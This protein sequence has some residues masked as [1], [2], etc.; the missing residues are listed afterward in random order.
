[1]A[2]SELRIL[3]TLNN[4]ITRGLSEA[5]NQLDS[6]G[7]RAEKIGKSL[8]GAG[9]RIAGIGAAGQAALSRMGLDMGTLITGAVDAEKALYGIASTAGKSGAAAKA[10]VSEWTIA[11]NQIAKETNQNQESVTAAMSQLIA[12]GMDPSAAVEML[13]PI[14]RAATAAQGDILDMAI[15]I[16]AGFSKFGIAPAEAAKSLDIMAQAGKRGKFE[17]KDMAGYFESL[18]AQAD[19]LGIKGQAGMAQLAAAAQI[20]RRASGDAASAANNLGN[21]LGKLNA[22]TTAKN[23]QE[24]GADLGKLKE[25]ARASGDYIG[26]M[27]TA[28]QKLTAGDSEKIASLFPDM[29]A[30]KFIQRMVKDLGDYKDIFADSMQ[31]NGVVAEDFKTQMQ[32]TA[33]QMDKLK[34]G[35]TASAGEGGALRGIMDALNDLASWADNHPDLAKWIIFGT[36][37]LVVGGAVIM[38]I[39]A[40][41]T[42]IGGIVTALSTLSVFLAANPVVL[43]ILGIGAAFTAGWA[44]GTWLNGQIDLAVQAVTGNQFATL[45]TAIYDMVQ[46]FADIPAKL[47]AQFEAWKAAGAALIANLKAGI[48]DK[49]KGAFGIGEKIKD[50]L[51]YVIDLHAEWLQVGRNIIQGIINGL[52]QKYKEVVDKLK[53]LGTDMLEGV[54]GVLRM[55]S[56]SKETEEIGMYFAEGMS[57]GIS[58]GSLGVVRSVEDMARAALDAGYAFDTLGDPLGGLADDIDAIEKGAAQAEKS[59]A[60]MAASAKNMPTEKAANYRDSKGRYL[61]SDAAERTAE[62]WRRTASDIERSLT[63]ALMRGFEGGKD[64]GRNFVDTIKNYLQTAFL[65]PIAV[66]IS[67]S[68]MG[69]VGL[70]SGTAIAGGA[71]V[72]ES[73]GMV[74]SLKTA[75]NAVTTGFAALGE[76]VGMYAGGIV[77]SLGASSAAAGS[78]GAAVATAMPWVI[79][80]VAVASAWKS[81]FGRKLKDSGVEGTF[82]DG[83]FTGN[84]YEYLKGGLFRSDKTNRSP[85]DSELDQAF[86]AQYAAQKMGNLMANAALGGVSTALDDFSH[87]IKLSLK[88]LNEEDAQKKI[89]EA[90]SGMNDAMATEV[91]NSLAEAQ[92]LTGLQDRS[93]KSIIQ[94][95]QYAVNEFG[96]LEYAMQDT[97]I[98]TIIPAVVAEWQRFALLGETASQTLSRLSTSLSGVNVAFDTLGLAL[99][100]V[101]LSGA[102]MA[103]SLATLFGGL[104]NMQQMTGAYYDAYY[105]D[106]EKLANT[107]SAVGNALG[108]LGTPMQTTKEGF[109]SLV[110]GLDLTTAYGQNAFVTLMG[111][112]PAFSTVADAAVENAKKTAEAEIARSK[113]IA[114]WQN[115]INVLTG[116]FTDQQIERAQT[117][118]TAAET[119]DTELVSLI[120]HFYALEDSTKAA[121]TATEGLKNLADAFESAAQAARDRTSASLESLRGE[122]EQL[123]IALLTAQ[124]DTAGAAKALRD[125]ETKGFTPLEVVLYDYNQSLRDQADAIGKAQ[126]AIE[127]FNTASRSIQSSQDVIAGVDDPVAAA[128]RTLGYAI[129]DFNSTRQSVTTVKDRFENV[130]PQVIPLAQAWWDAQP[131]ADRN[132][133]WASYDSPEALFNAAAQAIW[134]EWGAELGWQMPDA[135]G[136]VNKTIVTQLSPLDLDAI[137]SLDLTVGT[138]TDTQRTALAG[139]W[140]ALA[141]V[142]I[143]QTQANS[144][145]GSATP[146][147]SLDDLRDE[148]MKR[149]IDTQESLTAAQTAYADV[150]RSTVESMTDFLESLDGGA[151]PLESLSG[152]K[153]QFNTLAGRAASGDTSVYEELTPA[154]E[155]FLSLSKNYST[156][157]QEYRRDE[158]AVR[159]ALNAVIRV[160]QNELDKL[161]AEVAKASDPTKEAWLELQKA[162][163]DEANARVLLTAMAV[164]ETASKARFKLAEDDLQKRYLEAIRGVPNG[165][166]LLELFTDSIAAVTDTAVMPDFSEKFSFAD[167][168]T[169]H[170]GETD[171][172]DIAGLFAKDIS[173]LLPP[174]FIG[175]PFD[176]YELFLDLSAEALPA[177]FAGNTFDL[178]ELFVAQVSDILPPDFAGNATDLAAML[179]A[180]T[181]DVLPAGFAGNAFDAQSMMQTAID[182]MLSGFDP[183]PVVPVTPV[184]PVTPNQ[185]QILLS[186]WGK[187]AFVTPGAT[188]M[189]GLESMD[190]ALTNVGLEGAAAIAKASGVPMTMLQGMFETMR[191]GEDWYAAWAATGLPAFAI[192]TNYVPEDMVANI[193][194]GERIIPA[195]ENAEL[196]RRLQNP[197]GNNDALLGELK[198]LRAEIAQLREANSAENNAI[199]T[200]TG[201][202]QR[203]MQKWDVDGQPEVR[204]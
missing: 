69:A 70:S 158:A 84:N 35:A 9:M 133:A 115:K 203:V 129:D 152:A 102:A 96:E 139:V 119:G 125:L 172:P 42:A 156:S 112:A 195:A 17:L 4:Q 83:G 50:A 148:A 146:G 45:G 91:M 198:A 199:A 80:A 66:K 183:N 15:A 131:E 140:D 48:A 72:S 94:T 92:G 75:Y 28:I 36:A 7:A 40:T 132:A 10:M 47:S 192:G 150:L 162:T 38:G 29:E 143:A 194:Q 184:T 62:E 117:L 27:A 25:E 114:D 67:A 68:I 65:K 196:M 145:T 23:F 134:R 182:A 179:Y 167:I 11:I 56:P 33:A 61:P 86:D 178:Y 188:L 121:A 166:Q 87:T 90:F 20:S 79:G 8:E 126:A 81:L 93:I 136:M 55:Q 175:E 19:S 160:N 173:T 32:S 100:D 191:P 39:G 64:I 144:T 157:I 104:E 118:A 41:I 105:T 153:N 147:E 164:D 2:D 124:G 14:G 197:Q 122:S 127:S 37:G 185:N 189:A 151:T 52:Q 149:Y 128:R 89:E 109:R 76:T 95:M 106:A 116:V 155:K 73:F 5:G 78:F 88:G 154:A 200:N 13:K 98:T 201:K 202:S 53:G 74:S 163:T 123:S 24:M 34:I 176:L 63:D 46:W 77:E 137:Q 142:T 44:F 193:H 101:S 108:L 12:A 18:T 6:F 171:M 120:K 97:E 21:F 130:Y 138:W 59:L 103:S 174:G 135:D 22:E 159:A 187:S 141:G 49:L 30:G 110:E 57:L 161:P 180:Q 99:Y 26:Y 168:W 16:E 31:A 43:T 107:T 51:K 71:G 54:K 3:L 82:S 170:I 177:G 85:V 190:E 60:K 169:E 111:I 204:T 186:M 181:L 1:M 113:T 58:K 165:G